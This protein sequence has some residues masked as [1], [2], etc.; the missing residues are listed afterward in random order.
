ML[1]FHA[2]RLVS[3]FITIH[4]FP[5]LSTWLLRVDVQISYLGEVAGGVAP[6][7]MPRRRHSD[8]EAVA[9]QSVADILCKHE[10][11]T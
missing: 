7:A 11:Q 4:V 1:C 10:C 2:L 5:Q 9:H 6:P 8:A 3:S